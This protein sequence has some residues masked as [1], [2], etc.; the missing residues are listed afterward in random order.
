MTLEI[1]CYFIRHHHED[2]CFL[3]KCLDTCGMNCHETIRTTESAESSGI[4]DD[5]MS[6]AGGLMILPI[7][8]KGRI[9]AVVKLSSSVVKLCWKQG[10]VIT[11]ISTAV[12]DIDVALTYDSLF[13]T[14]R[15]FFGMATC[16]CRLKMTLHSGSF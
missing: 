9:H 13:F 14:G 10:G 15:Q 7:S 8:A 5:P 3:G 12:S 11:M 6:A 2:G 16:Q 4:R 1:F